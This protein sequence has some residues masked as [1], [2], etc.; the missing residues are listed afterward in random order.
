MSITI[1]QIGDGIGA[2]LESITSIKHVSTSP[3]KKI[4]GSLPAIIVVYK[5]FENVPESY[6]D[7]DT[8]HRFD[9]ELYLPT[10]PNTKNKYEELND[11]VDSIFTE[12]KANPGLGLDNEVYYSYLKSGETFIDESETKAYFGIKILIH[13]KVG[14]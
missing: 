3:Q 14:G 12:Y 1:N 5:G 7:Y 6:N 11:I 8:T 2:I 4:P 13:A 9:A 10:G